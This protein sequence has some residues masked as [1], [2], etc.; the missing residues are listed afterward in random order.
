[1]DRVIALKPAILGQIPAGPSA[2]F[3][4]YLDL[5]KQE[6]YDYV[7][8]QLGAVGISQSEYPKL[9]ES[10]Q[11]AQGLYA[12][13]KS[14]GIQIPVAVIAGVSQN[15]Q[16]INV[17]TSE[18]KEKTFEATATTSIPG[19]PFA[20][21]NTVGIYPAPGSGVVAAPKGSIKIGSAATLN[22]VATSARPATAAQYNANGI[23]SYVY[24]ASVL[25]TIGMQQ[26]GLQ[27]N[28]PVAVAGVLNATFGVPG[29]DSQTAGGGTTIQNIAPTNVN[30][31]NYI[32]ICIA[33]AGGDC[34]YNYG[35]TDGQFILQVPLNAIVT[36]PQP[37]KV[38]PN[39]GRPADAQYSVA[40]WYPQVGGGC[41]MPNT[42]FADR[43]SVS[44]AVL[45]WNIPVAQFGT[46]SS[47]T[48]CKVPYG[49]TVDATFQITMYVQGINGQMMPARITSEQGLK[50]ADT[51]RIPRTEF[52]YGCLPVGTR[53]TLA[54][55]KSKPIEA[56]RHGDRVK[57]GTRVLTVDNYMTGDEDRPL[58]RIITENRTSARMTEMHPVPT[59]DGVKLAKDLTT[60][61]FVTTIDGPSRIVR[62]EIVPYRGEVRNL[63]VGLRDTELPSTDIVN[64]TF[65]ADGILVGDGRMQAHYSR[66][67][68]ELP[69][70]VLS[71]LPP[72]WRVDFYNAELRSP[73]THEKPPVR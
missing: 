44:N 52:V 8:A 29:A 40:F 23:F 71:R 66:A 2:G 56:L 28:D 65:F 10:L 39:T 67:K 19:N 7:I 12:K 72:E 58:R 11:T 42:T 45:S 15:L 16:P 20:V 59:R 34:D 46:L 13:A 60:G 17:L 26:L 37:V 6:D 5:G 54:D 43:L 31:N 53:V 51:E 69:A 3:A 63:D 22:T 73:P 48:G 24:P 70:A 4:T 33:R 30:K 25:G 49:V 61:D 21:L 68:T 41:P 18:E 35:K 1:M 62:I 50:I 64:R 9:Y 27:R 55:G 57:S 38:D 47:T 32:K 14:L 36:F